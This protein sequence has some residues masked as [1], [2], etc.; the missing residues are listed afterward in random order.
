MGLLV[1]FLLSYLIGSLSWSYIF[2]K[3]LWN[4]DIRTKGSGNAGTSNMIINHG[5]KLGLLVFFLDF[6]K[7]FI[8]VYIIKYLDFLDISYERL[9]FIQV[10]AGIFVVLGHIYPVYFNFKGGKGT[11]TGVGIVLGINPLLG[12][13][14]GII[15]LIVSFMTKYIAIGGILFW[16]FN[17]I[18][19]YIIYKNIAISLIFLLMFFFSAFL[20]RRNIA[21]ILK[22]EEIYIKKKY[23]DKDKKLLK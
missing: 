10:I 12:A 2:S 9:L 5:W 7:G 6:I 14:T 17:S 1:Y 3:V 22:G 18:G 21:R 23:E 16:L 19:F 15:I 11:A 20:H 13:I 4:E 8:V